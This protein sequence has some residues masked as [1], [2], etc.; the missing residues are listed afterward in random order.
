VTARTVDAVGSREVGYQVALLPWPKRWRKVL[1]HMATHHVET[2]PS[3]DRN[4]VANPKALDG[5][6]RVLHDSS[7][8]WILRGR[9]DLHAHRHLGRLARIREWWEWRS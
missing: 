3:G 6:H 8:A 5:F 7:D 2:C 1:D 9:P 4:Q